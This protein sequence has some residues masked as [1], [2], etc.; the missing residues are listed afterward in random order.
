MSPRPISAAD[1]ASAFGSRTDG[2]VV[3]FE[4]RVR[5]GNLG[6]SVLR[7]HYEAYDAMADEVLGEIV[8]EAMDRFSAGEIA[9]RHRSGSLEIGDVA[10]AIAA[11]APHRAAAFEAVRYVIEEIKQRLPIW[12]RE[13]Y[14][15]GTSDWLDGAA[16]PVAPA[17]PGTPGEAAGA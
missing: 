9:V 13:E 7:L 17:D 12:K 2:A 8:A 15:D 16:P 6:R 5:A 1:L 11:A 14:A 10:V 3:T 4:G